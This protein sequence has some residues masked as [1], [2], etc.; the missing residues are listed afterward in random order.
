MFASSVRQAVK[1]AESGTWVRPGQ[2]FLKPAISSWFQGLPRPV[3]SLPTLGILYFGLPWDLPAADSASSPSSEDDESELTAVSDSLLASKPGIWVLLL[4]EA[5]PE[6][7]SLLVQNSSP[8]CTDPCCL[9]HRGC[10]CE[11]QSFS[12][13]QNF[14][15]LQSQ[16]ICDRLPGWKGSHS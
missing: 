5:G 7:F 11:K 1:I 6:R 12:I 3:P 8:G 15:N 9:F 4:L 16:K 14:S 2:S 10:N 13:G